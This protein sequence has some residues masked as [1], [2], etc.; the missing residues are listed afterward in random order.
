[1][2]EA[3][4]DGHG[5]DEEDAGGDGSSFEV[6]YLAGGL[7]RERCGGD[8][9]AGETADAAADEVRE[10]ND[11]PESAEAERETENGGSDAE[12]NDVREGIKIGAE[13]R[14]AAFIEA[15]DVAVECIEGQGDEWEDKSGPEFGDLFIGDESEAEK[16]GECAAARVAEGKKIRQGVGADHGEALFFLIHS[17][18]SVSRGGGL[19]S[20]R[21]VSR[22]PGH[23][24]QV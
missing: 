13:E 4:D 3:I 19:C 18:P 2:A 9:K 20:R 11:I 12:G 15:G 7:V 6:F 24:V 21:Y 8:V 5:D 22:T 14:L 23:R 16:N 1:M 17:A 10:A